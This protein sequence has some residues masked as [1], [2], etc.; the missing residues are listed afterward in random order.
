MNRRDCLKVTVGTGVT[1][2]IAACGQASPPAAPA[3]PTEAP[4]PAETKPAGPT[5][6]APTT[7]PAAPTAKPGEAA[8]PSAAAIPAGPEQYGPSPELVAAAEKEGKVVVYHGSAADSVAKFM[9][10]FN[11]RFPRID[12]GETLV[13]QEAQLMAK[14]MAETQS[15]Q[16]RVDVFFSD[17]DTMMI[18]LQKRNMLMQYD[19]PEY[20][21]YDPKFL[22][23][24]PGYFAG[25][26]LTLIGIAY[27]TDSVKEADAPKSWN[28][29]LDPKHKGKISVFNSS[30]SSPFASWYLMPAV[31]GN[32]YWEKLSQQDLR[33]YE[34][35]AQILDTLASGE[36]PIT[37]MFNNFRLKTVADRGLPIKAVWPAEGVPT[38]V[39]V[40]GILAK[41]PHPN[42]AKLFHDWFMSREGMN[43]AAFQ[44]AGQLA[45]RPDVEMGPTNPDPTKLN[46]LAPTDPDA[47]S[48]AYSEFKPAWDKIVGMR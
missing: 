16:N 42:A 2:L 43:I 35:S 39:S 7:A 18:D 41:A 38:F 14:I 15:N 27:N 26:F 37:M 10:A 13:E 24:P 8:K 40:Q 5:A 32:D 19:S 44:I 3:K 21:H 6:A 29:L 46:L 4:K 31:V 33:T 25:T 20:K 30:A 23:K 9:Q 36:T 28:D 11:E 47:Y 17:L 12:I 45:A 48:K 1:M 22:S 34:S